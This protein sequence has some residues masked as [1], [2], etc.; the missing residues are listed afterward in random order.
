MVFKCS[1][2]GSCMVYDFNKDHLVCPNCDSA[3]EPDIE[4]DDKDSF[5]TCP[6]CGGQLNLGQYG[7]ARRCNYCDS[8]V[9]SDTRLGGDNKPDA[10]IPTTITKKRVFELLTEKFRKYL[11]IIPEV[12]SESRLKEV[13][14]EY[15]PYWVYR[16]SIKAA[17]AGTIQESVTTGNT[18]VKDTYSVMEAWSF[19]MKNVPVDASEK[20]PDEIMDELE[21]FDFKGELEFKPEYLSG[22]ESEIANH[23]SDHYKEEACYKVAGRVYDF[24]LDNLNMTYPHA[25][26]LSCNTVAGDTNLDIKTA[27]SEYYLLPVYRYSYTLKN[28]TVLDYYVNGQTEEIF[29][30]APISEKRLWTAIAATVT[31]FAGIAAVV[32]TIL[33]LIGGAV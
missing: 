13:M 19:D 21:P 20:M 22:S 11:C 3:G 5:D 8:Y 15:V 23:E 1:S 33:M 17:Y 4:Y 2:C 24:I 31:A 14:I 26:N 27:G 6:I 25:T 12:F 9:V 29:G 28:G 32:T 10:I 30:S 18:T 7:S 16:F